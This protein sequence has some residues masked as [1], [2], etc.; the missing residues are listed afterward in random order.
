MKKTTFLTI[1][2][3][4]I[5]LGSISA[6][7]LK[8]TYNFDKAEII[9][10]QKNDFS[11]IKFNN[12]QEYGIPGNPLLPIFC[13][14]I[15]LPQGQ[16]LKNIKILSVE[17]YDA[18]KN[19]SIKPATTPRPLSL[20]SI[21]IKEAKINKK[22]YESKG[23]Y[24][25]NIILNTSTN[26]L[27]G[28]SIASFS[29]SPIAYFPSENLI[30]TIKTITV[31]LETYD[32]EKAAYA[33]KFIRN[34]KTI[35]KR[36]NNIVD[37]KEILESYNYPTS[38]NNENFDILIIT[39]NALAPAFNEYVKYK[40]S[41]GYTC[42]VKKT[43]DIYT[44]YSGVDN[45]EMI[46]NCIIDFYQNNETSFVILGGDADHTETQNIVPAR[47]FY[48]DMG[49]ELEECLPSDMYYSGLD[50]NW[51][52]DLNG[53]WGEAGEAD[54]YAEISIG[55]ICVDKAE[56][57]ENFTHKLIMYQDKPV[58][59][60]IEKALM[61]GEYLW[62]DSYGGS[63]KDEIANGCSLYGYT[64]AGIS[65]NFSIS[66]LY[67]MISNWEEDDIFEQFNN[68]GL[69][70]I[71][72]LGHSNTT[73]NMKMS[74][75]A[76]NTNNF[77]NDGN[78]RGYVIGYS[79]GCYNGAFDNRNS[80][81]MYGT[82]DCFAEKFTVIK[83]GEVACV[84]NSR[85]GWG[86]DNTDG[87]SQYLDRE[88]FDA[89]FGEGLTLI[90][91]ANGDSKE[92]N[93]AFILENPTIRW[94]AYET[95]L[96]GDPTL[97][98][99]TASP[100]NINCN[101]SPSISLGD[102]QFSIETDCP[103]ARV[104]ITQNGV[105]IGRCFTNENG[106]ATIN[107]FNPVTTK[108]SLVVSVIAHNKFRHLGTVYVVNNE[109]YILFK[110]YQIDDSQGNNN[111]NIDY[112]ET[113]NLSISSTNIGTMPAT[114]LCLT[115][116]TNNPS[117]NITDNTENISSFEI[118]DTLNLMNAFSME[119]A[120]N[121]PD[122][123]TVFVLK[124]SSENTDNNNYFEI[125]IH[126]P[127]LKFKDYQIDDSQGNNNG[128][129]D[130]GENFDL[131]LGIINDGSSEASNVLG[132]LS[133][134]NDEITINSTSQ[135]FENIAGE[136]I[137]YK[138]YN[139]SADAN[140]TN[141]SIANFELNITADKEISSS[142]NFYTFIG[143]AYILIIDL[144]KNN[145]SAPVIQETIA[146][147]GLGSEYTKVF[148]DNFDDYNTVFLS[149]GVLWDNNKLT[150]NQGQILS[151]FLDN[152]GNLYLEGGNAWDNN[153]P[154]HSKFN[155]NN[156]SS[157]ID[158]L[159]VNG[160]SQSLAQDMN[161]VYSGDKLFIE[162]IQA[163]EPAISLLENQNSYSCVVAYDQ[164]TYKTIGSTIEFGGLVNGCFPSV[165]K[166]L[167]AKYLE[168]FGVSYPFVSINNFNI[169]DDD[170]FKISPNPIK[171]LSRI[172]YSLSKNSKICIEIFNVKGEKIRCLIN[173]NQA[174]GNYSIDFNASDDS[175]NKLSEGIYL[176]RMMSD[177][178]FYTK[179]IIVLKD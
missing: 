103:D 41:T 8:Y 105:L 137:V 77:T 169:I 86:N 24:P 56:E 144:D 78:S 55:R 34:S 3:L 26:F 107:F 21:K 35:T 104:G 97:D 70:L 36:I 108:D 146:K 102:E 73:Y 67:E 5:I 151:D 42:F 20:K 111:G 11:E 88:F 72:H 52:T 44:E 91:D 65:D 98:V 59:Q 22:I 6:Q 120:N 125:F 129:I 172:N 25:E 135:S 60:D 128:R 173:K 153:T 156:F 179:K 110:E 114:D 51:D 43:E 175:G 68:T 117:I 47:D 123:T 116:S 138:N 163:V 10:N 159:S 141:G 16:K 176:C 63:S 50:G 150:S 40:E 131:L 126:A 76:L 57:I 74:A 133:T 147:L 71:N 166:N 15:L 139:I 7:T 90:G 177:N 170:I 132:E 61:V 119:I 12:C 99:W 178:N 84:A 162:E 113:I 87:A 58:V 167:M 118:G 13:K 171:N 31:E 154:V 140:I 83:T 157:G 14:S 1:F 18:E 46:R 89:I 80:G 37:N 149:L 95:N 100:E 122:D 92:D 143:K 124:A 66:R 45:Q 82:S 49:F 75:S 9:K 17:Y 109:P 165:R 19:I 79:Q 81:G 152:G 23:R 93:V 69:H 174:A 145:N 158:V 4:F 96:F 148:P 94:C 2:S 53:R 106:D 30:K 85:Y 32:S 136:Q 160:I 48:L 38:K 54:L 62:G 142:K 161:F 64:T 130:P 112:G 29:L 121:I 27:C 164:G 168:F 101:Y 155:I 134:D 33:Q 39:N 28:H 127:I 115:L